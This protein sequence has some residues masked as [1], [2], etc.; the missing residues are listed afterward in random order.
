MHTVVDMILRDGGATREEIIARVD[1]PS[2][3]IAQ[4]AA[5]N[6]LNI[7]TT[8]TGRVT[9]YSISA[10]A[11][12]RQ[13]ARCFDRRLLPP[14]PGPPITDRPTWPATIG[15]EPARPFAAYG[16]RKDQAGYGQSNNHRT[17]DGRMESEMGISQTQ[18]RRGLGMLAHTDIATWDKDPD[19]MPATSRSR[20]A[21]LV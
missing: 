1:W 15:P 16:G 21:R 17:D 13:A 4:I 2:I 12:P 8:K 3:S 5:R 10:A 7:I 11:S 14:D 20:C 18:S 6:G 19:G 9:R